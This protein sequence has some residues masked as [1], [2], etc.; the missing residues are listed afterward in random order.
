VVTAAVFVAGMSAGWLMRSVFVRWL[1]ERRIERA[2]QE[3]ELEWWQ[4]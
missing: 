1:Y 4:S 2:S 3:T